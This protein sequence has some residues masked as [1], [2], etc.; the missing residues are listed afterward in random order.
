M[1]NYNNKAVHYIGFTAHCLM[2][3]LYKNGNDVPVSAW[4]TRTGGIGILAP[5]FCACICTPKIDVLVK[6]FVLFDT[7]MA[8]VLN[9]P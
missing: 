1:Q 3:H 7:A 4:L 6:V 2:V 8:H 5:E 9:V